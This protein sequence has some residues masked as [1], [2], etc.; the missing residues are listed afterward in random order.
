[1][2]RA[3]LEPGMI[4]ENDRGQRMHVMRDPTD[5]SLK[6]LCWTDGDGGVV[7]LEQ[8]REDCNRRRAAIIDGKLKLVD[9][10]EG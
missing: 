3:L 1:M 4:Y 7:G 8:S 6:F 9:Q 10:I 5:M 2:S